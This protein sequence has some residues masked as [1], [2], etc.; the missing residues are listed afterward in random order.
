M[1]GVRTLPGGEE[2]TDAMVRARIREDEGLAA[3]CRRFWGCRCRLTVA[4]VSEMA[5]R[6]HG[7]R[8]S[9][10]GLAQVCG[11]VSLRGRWGTGGRAPS[12]REWNGSQ[13]GQGATELLLPRPVLGK[14]QGDPACRADE[15]SGQGEDPS[16]EGPGRTWQGDSPLLHPELLRIRGRAQAGPAPAL[17]YNDSDGPTP[18]KR[19][20][21]RRRCPGTLPLPAGN[22]SGRTVRPWAVTPT[23]LA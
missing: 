14:M 16:S 13:P 6:G 21:I 18:A 1:D 23:G 9:R 17:A 3:V 8:H 4:V 19:P 12:G 20:Y 7:K 5:G 11:D 2:V 15:P 10:A 22:P